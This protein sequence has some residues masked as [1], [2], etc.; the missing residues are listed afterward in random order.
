M[1]APLRKTLCAPPAVAR[2]RNGRGDPSCWVHADDSCNAPAARTHA[3]ECSGPDA[4]GCVWAPP[5]EHLAELAYRGE[6]FWDPVFNSTMF[7]KWW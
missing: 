1:H 5:P 6:G 3:Q 4:A 7:N 2:R